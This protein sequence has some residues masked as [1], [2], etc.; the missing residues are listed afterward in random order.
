LFR[1][2]GKISLL[3]QEQACQDQHVISACD[4]QDPC[5]SPDELSQELI[6]QSDPAVLQHPESLLPSI[7]KTYFFYLYGSR[8]H[9]TTLPGA[10]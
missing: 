8:L 9:Q 5:E 1:L 3:L 7:L 4:L 10:A 2:P 6:Y